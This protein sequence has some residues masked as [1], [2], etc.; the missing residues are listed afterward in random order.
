M[1]KKGIYLL[2]V[3]FLTLSFTA[4][5][6]DLLN[7]DIRDDLTGTWSVTEN[8]NFKKSI[9]YYTVTISK[10]LTDTSVIRVNN[11]YA[12]SE[13]VEAEISDMNVSIPSQTVAGFTFSG[14]GTISGNLKEIN[15][16][17][18]VDHNNG[19]IDQVTATYKKN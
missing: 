4:C 16:S 17:Y 11:F 3:I 2:A 1:N 10:S 5:E 13:T 6:E 8:N 9:E 18:T 19:S 15:W 14:Y 12:I 7:D